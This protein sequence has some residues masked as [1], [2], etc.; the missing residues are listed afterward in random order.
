[1]VSLNLFVVVASVR[2]YTFH[3]SLSDL[4]ANLKSTASK[5]VKLTDVFLAEFLAVGLITS[6][7]C[8]T[9]VHADMSM[10]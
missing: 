6:Y 2:S 4:G 5:K 8:Y 3:S 7:D 10:L 9:N 1:M